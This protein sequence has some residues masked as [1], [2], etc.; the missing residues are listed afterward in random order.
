MS[1]EVFEEKVNWPILIVL[2]IIVNIVANLAQGVLGIQGGY[3]GCIY[4]MGIAS[5]PFTMPTLALIL[6]MLAF[7]TK[8]T[9]KKLTPTTLAALYVMGLVSSLSIGNFNDAYYSWPVGSSSRVWRA[10]PEVRNVM[11]TLWWVP[12][13]AAV[14]PT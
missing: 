12:P 5:I 9:G 6:P 8:F 3:F 7:L 10:I 1:K 4:S 2:A 14:A 11:S 13:E